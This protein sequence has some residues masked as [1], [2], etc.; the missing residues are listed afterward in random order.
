[1]K[2][3]SWRAS[4]GTYKKKE[5]MMTTSA[6]PVSPSLGDLVSAFAAGTASPV[7]FLE[8]ALARI[9]RDNGR[10]HAFEH[11]ARESARAEARASAERF[12]RGAHRGPLDGIPVGVK[13]VLAVRGMPLGAGSPTLKGQ[14]AS[15]D[16]AVVG[17]LR[18]A[19][20]V[21]VGINSCDE[22]ALSTVGA[23]AVNPVDPGRIAGGSSGGSAVAVAA[24]MCPVS[25]GTDTGGSI[26]IPAACCGVVGYKPSR[27]VL[28]TE[29]LIP[30]AASL[31][32]LGV[33]ARTAADTAIVYR[34]LASGTEHRL[35][36][37]GGLRLG[38][39]QN[40]VG[41]ADA[42]VQES[43]AAFL[44][45]LENLGV[46]A[47]PVELP[48]VDTVRAIHHTVV[49]VELAAYHHES[50]PHLDRCGEVLR[51]VVGLADGI[52]GVDYFR[53]RSA[54]ADLAAQV[55]SALAGV[56]ALV[57]PTLP[58]PVPSTAAHELTVDSQLVD[59]TSAL[60]SFTA[61][62]NHTGHPVASLPVPGAGAAAASGAQI[63]GPLG[64]DDGLL[65]IVVALEDALR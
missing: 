58:V 64:S 54:R 7:D 40:L 21:I 65:S 17:R 56:D 36:K 46:H 52:S 30:M 41:V 12:S 22:Y 42:E 63:V 15:A 18:R 31:D 13:D 49:P 48:S 27:G 57:M 60:V 62:F 8:G 9:D 5:T 38:V 23:S 14:I 3:P 1:M 43:F 53:A 20:A 37:V 34:T 26:R 16:S 39:P 28:D 44:S 45:R 19:G 29:G 51:M 33:T 24:G 25:I 55:D 47:V 61:L 35:E 59:I 2:F 50:N 32:H 6:L 10:L 11:V 4:R